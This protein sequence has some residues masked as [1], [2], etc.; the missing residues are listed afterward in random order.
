LLLW[1]PAG[2]GR[3]LAQSYGSLDTRFEF[4]LK[5]R[6][7]PPWGLELALSS[8]ATYPCAGYRLSTSVQWHHDTL[9]VA[10]LGLHRPSPC[11]PLGS[12]AT[13]TLFLGDLGDTT[14]VLRFTYRG[15][16]DRYRLSTSGRGR[17]IVPLHNRFTST[18]R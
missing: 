8:T 4:S 9:T 14:V 1:P 16:E 7:A 18:H 5:N 17:D 13:A 12:V 6:K 11:V 10:I 2:E 3:A 15:H